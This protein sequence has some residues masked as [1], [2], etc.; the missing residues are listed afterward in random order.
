MNKKL[1]LYLTTSLPFLAAALSLVLYFAIPESGKQKQMPHPYYIAFLLTA[2]IALAVCLI[3]GIFA[4]DFGAKLK[5]KLPLYAGLFF[6]LAILNTLVSKTRLLPVLYFPSLDRVCGLIWTQKVFLLKNLVFSLGLLIQG[7]LFGLITGFFTGLALGYNRHV[8]YWLNPVT[9]F[10]GPVPTTAWIPLALSVFPTT[11]SANVF[12]IAF[13]V[14]FPV[15][16]MTASGIQ[17]V[18]KTFFEVSETLGARTFFKVFRVAVPA[19]LPQIF[20]GLFYGIVSSFATL[21]AVEMNGNAQGIGWYI[22]WQKS[23]MMYDGVYAGLIIIAVLCSLV[24]T[25]LFKV[26]DKIMVWQKG[27][28]RW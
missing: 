24:L 7:F 1:K 6:F 16:L 15:T 13:A 2:V 22:N 12:L 20:L 8:G 18:N 9:K 14:W 10:L 4:K 28:I 25:L 21:M 19:S 11:H 23:V 26:R 3:A 17:S 27:V 5:G